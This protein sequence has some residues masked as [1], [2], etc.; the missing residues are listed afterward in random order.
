MSDSL[1]LAIVC[2]CVVV[3]LIAL[4]RAFNDDRRNSD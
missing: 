1:I 2:V 4:V 3:M